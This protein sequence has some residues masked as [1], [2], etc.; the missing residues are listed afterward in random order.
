MMN[1]AWYP[2]TLIILGAVIFHYK[3]LEDKSYNKNQNSSS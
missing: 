3:K 1:G 2:I